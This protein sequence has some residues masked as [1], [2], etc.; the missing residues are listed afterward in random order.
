MVG[1]RRQKNF[2]PSDCGSSAKAHG[3]EPVRRSPTSLPAWQQESRL[4]AR[5]QRSDSCG[6]CTTSGRS[7][8]CPRTVCAL[9]CVPIGSQGRQRVSTAG[10][11]RTDVLQAHRR[12]RCRDEEPAPDEILPQVRRRLPPGRDRTDL[13]DRRIAIHDDDAGSASHDTEAPRE[14]V[15]ELPDANRPHVGQLSHIAEP[16]ASRGASLTPRGGGG[17]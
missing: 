11:R 1:G 6:C 16:R 2:Q 9:A 4:K 3:A 8:S 7:R 5:R 12:S 10:H 14:L 15:L 13:C 17:I